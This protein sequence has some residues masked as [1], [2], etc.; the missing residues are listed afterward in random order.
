MVVLEVL[1]AALSLAVIFLA[2]KYIYLKANFDRRIEEW[3]GKEE[4]RIR[5]DA[6]GRSAR[7]LSGKTLEKLIPFLDKFP[8]DAHDMRWL[9]DPVDFIIF[10]GYSSEKSPKEIVFCEVKSGDGK[11]SKVQS[12]IKELIGNKKVRW[13]E[14]RI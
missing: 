1:V 7:T 8:Y 10:N 14:F 11:L 4:A 12:E 3:L 13:F 2:M 6:I 9:G 5:K